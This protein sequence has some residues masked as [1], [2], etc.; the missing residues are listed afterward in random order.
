MNDIEG[1]TVS[2]EY[3]YNFQK[4]EILTNLIHA[5]ALPRLGVSNLREY[6]R[7]GMHVLDSGCVWCF[8]YE[9]DER[10]ALLWMLLATLV[11]LA[12]GLLV[13]S[14]T[15]NMKM[16]LDTGTGVLAALTTVQGVLIL[17]LK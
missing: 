12:I 8:C 3:V 10:L 14:C 17:V 15:Q 6:L 13:G 16:G 2:R 1:H 4:D 5:V 11:A 9:F 7:R